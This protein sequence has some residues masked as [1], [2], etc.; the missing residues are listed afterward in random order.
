MENEKK[1]VQPMTLDMN[2]VPDPPVTFRTIAD[3]DILNVVNGDNH[4][5]LVEI[6]GYGLQI[7]FNMQ[8]L[9]SLEDIDA[10]C[11]GISELFRRTI[12]Q[13]LLDHSKQ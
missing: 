3:H 9:K 8:Y 11:R 13:K 4:E 7:N 1:D 12:M 6:S 10:A 5:V 2:S